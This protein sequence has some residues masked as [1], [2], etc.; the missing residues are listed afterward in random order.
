[1]KIRALCYKCLHKVRFINCAIT[2]KQVIC[3]FNP[4]KEIVRKIRKNDCIHFTD[5]Q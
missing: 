4:E 1:M 3:G 2:G 5:K